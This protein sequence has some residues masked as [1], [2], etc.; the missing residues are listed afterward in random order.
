MLTPRGRISKTYDTHVGTRCIRHEYADTECPTR[1]SC[2]EDPSFFF[3]ERRCHCRDAPTVTL[4][5]DC[6]AMANVVFPWRFTRGY[7]D[8]ASSASEAH[9]SGVP[10]TD[11]HQR[12][13]QENNVYKNVDER[14]SVNMALALEGSHGDS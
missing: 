14:Y 7:R 8:L 10:L 12:F 5:L 13:P 4:T 2:P 1:T 3:C 11:G 6:S 9:G